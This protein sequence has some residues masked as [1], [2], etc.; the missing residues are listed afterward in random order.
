MKEKL[1]EIRDGLC[2]TIEARRAQLA[3]TV[4][5][6]ASSRRAIAE[7]A[8]DSSALLAIIE[9]EYR[10][11]VLYLKVAGDPMSPILLHH[12]QPLL[13]AAKRA[14]RP[15]RAFETYVQVA[16]DQL[17]EAEAALAQ[18]DFLIGALD[19]P[20]DPHA[21]APNASEAIIRDNANV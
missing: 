8:R 20:R 13:S 5:A 11:G 3:S 4:E 15:S 17:E 18:L 9:K 2:K 19:A 16:A 10:D 1:A 21:N 12:L 6:Q 14:P 7:E